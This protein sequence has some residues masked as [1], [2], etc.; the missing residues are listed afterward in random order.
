MEPHRSTIEDHN[1]LVMLFNQPSMD[2]AYLS[3]ERKIK[4]LAAGAL[5][6]SSLWLGG[7][8]VSTPGFSLMDAR[9]ET[10][11]PA[12]GYLP[13]Q[14]VPPKREKPAMALDE[15]SRLKQELTAARGHQAAV[16][17]VQ[18][19]VAPIEPVKP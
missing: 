3:N 2:I 6:L 7:C 4:A 15:R 14:D 8:A 16:A 1:W 18:G 11:T 19:G 17:K 12:S 13:V 10:P 5:L 9:A